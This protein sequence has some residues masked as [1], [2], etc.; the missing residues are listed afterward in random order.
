MFLGNTSRN[1]DV[2]RHH[3]PRSA[4]LRPGSLGSRPRPL[5]DRRSGS[6]KAPA[7]WRTP[8]V[9]LVALL[10]TGCAT[11]HYAHLKFTGDPL[12]DGENAIQNGPP[13]DRVLWEYRTAL[14]AMRRGQFDVAK[15]NLDDAI[16][17]ISSIYGKDAAARKSR[18]TFQAEAKKTFLGE[19]YERVM[20]WYLRGILYWRDGEPDNARAC[21]RSGQLADS[22][23]EK[24]AWASDYV[25][26]DYLDGYITDKLGGDGS[27]AM[28]RAGAVAQQWKPPAFSTNANALVF[29]DYGAAPVK[30][31]SG[32]YG[33]QLRFRPQASHARNAVAK[34]G[35]TTGKAVPY[36]DLVFQATTRGGRVMDHVLANK[37]VFKGATDTFGNVALITGAALTT[38]RETEVA[39]LATMGAGLISKILASAANPAADTRAWDNLPQSL[40]FVA[41][42]LPPGAHTL[43][44]EFLDEAGRPLSGQSRTINFEMPAGGHDKVI[45]V[46]DKS[47]TPQS[48]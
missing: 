18:G 19:P 7:G 39:G 5:E 17:R 38:R 13:R 24:K 14:A 31:A 3:E 23:A 43:T 15:R 16:A 29:V 9:L 48:Q 12:V 41:F 2:N 32:A 8:I 42:E 36:D 11:D 45:Y 21:F 10:L 30:F 34:I 20:A 46:S 25:L 28:K 40:S 47:S 4:G 33:E 22:D 1:G 6:S 37:A 44:V 26:L 35:S 27:D